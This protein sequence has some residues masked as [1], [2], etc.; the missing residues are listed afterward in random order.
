MPNR[1]SE[2]VLSRASLV[3]PPGMQTPGVK[4]VSVELRWTTDGEYRWFREDGQPTT[5]HA[6]T[7]EKATHLAELTWRRWELV[8][9]TPAS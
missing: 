8:I 9:E 2:P 1:Q 4:R 6:P 5:L 3:A 7:V